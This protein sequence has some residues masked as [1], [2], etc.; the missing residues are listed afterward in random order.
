[1]TANEFFTAFSDFLSEDEI[2]KPYS[3]KFKNTIMDQTSEKYKNRLFTRTGYRVALIF[4]EQ[5]GK[6]HKK[7]EDPTCYKAY[8]DWKNKDIEKI[9][10]KLTSEYDTVM[11]IGKENCDEG[12]NFAIFDP[13][14]VTEIELI[15]SLDAFLETLENQ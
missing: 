13:N 11:Y 5:Y 2:T 14:I 10:E 4:F 9:K 3:D 15:G 8:V 1:M 12:C 7:F 6:K